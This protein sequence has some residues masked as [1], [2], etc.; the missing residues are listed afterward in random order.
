MVKT[1]QGGIKVKMK[2]ENCHSQGF[3][4]KNRKPWAWQEAA[5]QEA[6]Q[7]LACMTKSV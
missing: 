3:K 4:S 7:L 5:A 6:G 1:E 2:I